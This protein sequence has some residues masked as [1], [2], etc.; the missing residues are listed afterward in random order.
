MESLLNRNRINVAISRAM[1]K[2]ILIRSKSLT[3]YMPSSVDGVIQ[4]SAFI[5]LCQSDTNAAD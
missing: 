1:W 2:A 5:D 3:A 4:L